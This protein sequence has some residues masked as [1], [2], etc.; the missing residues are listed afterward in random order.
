MLGTT[1]INAVA[2]LQSTFAQRAVLK[3][4]CPSFLQ[5]TDPNTY[6]NG[7]QPMEIKTSTTYTINLHNIRYGQPRHIYLQYGCRPQEL[8]GVAGGDSSLYVQ[9]TL[10]YHD[11]S[12]LCRGTAECHI[13]HDVSMLSLDDE[14]WHVSRT[15]VFNWA[16]ALYQ[17][18]RDDARKPL[19]GRS[20]PNA[21]QLRRFV[22]GL[23]AYHPEHRNDPRNAALIKDLLDDNVKEGEVSM[24]LN[25]IPQKCGAPSHWKKWGRF[26][27]ASFPI[28]WPWLS[29]RV[30]ISAR[31][32]GAPLPP[33]RSLLP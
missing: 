30:S 18:D 17:L 7:E 2:N 28:L 32:T 19:L 27:L 31:P 13:G 21:D 14:A 26:Y 5:L 11:R 22:E 6:I 15:H 23:P 4:Q 33:R 16:F 25:Q 12:S 29:F 8:D 9:A 24:A 1:F 10:E 20:I 3:V